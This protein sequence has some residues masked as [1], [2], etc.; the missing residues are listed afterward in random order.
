MIRSVFVGSEYSVHSCLSTNCAEV[1][2]CKWEG[3]RN[4]QER[5]WEI[6]SLGRREDELT[7]T[8][9]DSRGD[10]APIKVILQTPRPTSPRSTAPRSPLENGVWDLR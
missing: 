2:L 9:H 5:S 10:P 8:G 6:L 1:V 4:S 3:S 7:L